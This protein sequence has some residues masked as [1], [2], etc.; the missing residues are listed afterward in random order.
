MFELL[1][2]YAILNSLSLSVWMHLS[3][4]KNNYERP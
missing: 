1:N 4:T 2:N 3:G